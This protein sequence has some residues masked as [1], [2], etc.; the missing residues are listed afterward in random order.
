MRKDMAKVIVERPRKG[1]SSR[2]M[3][4]KGLGREV[5]RIK[6]DPDY[7][8]TKAPLRDRNR[9][10]KEL[11]ENL[12]PL[13]RYLLKNV[14]RPWDKVRSEISEHVRL[15]SA[16][17]KHILDHVKNYVEEHVEMIGGV[18]HRHSYGGTK[19]IASRSD[20]HPE[21][22]VCPKSGLLKIAKPLKKKVA[23]DSRKVKQIAGGPGR[24]VFHNGCWH[25]VVFS[26]VY[27]TDL[28][29]TGRIMGYTVDAVLGYAT[30]P[31]ILDRVWGKDR[32]RSRYATGLVPMTKKD[33]KAL[34]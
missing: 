13:W 9:R 22:Y 21:M 7:A 5:S 20:K 33:I 15:S 25:E 30:T 27:S 11:N 32:G 29:P 10:T 24:A 12:A 2:G 18:P 3:E 16:V 8:P 34:L 14:G 19:P 4:G 26:Y 23:T 6:S 31:T 17:Q 1:G 28:T